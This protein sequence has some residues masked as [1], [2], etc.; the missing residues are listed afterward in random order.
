MS[1]PLSALPDFEENVPQWVTELDS[2]FAVDFVSGPPFE[3]GEALSR[4]VFARL[5]ALRSE[6]P[7]CR[8]LFEIALLAEKAYLFDQLRTNPAAMDIINQHRAK[9]V[10]EALT[11]ATLSQ[12]H[13]TETRGSSLFRAAFVASM[14]FVSSDRTI[15]IGAKVF[16]SM[17]T[18]SPYRVYCRFWR[19]A[20][21]LSVWCLDEWHCDCP[22]GKLFCS[23]AKASLMCL[24]TVLKGKAFTVS[25]KVVEVLSQSKGL[26]AVRLLRLGAALSSREHVS[27]PIV[28]HPD[29]LDFPAFKG[30]CL[31]RR[32]K[33][34]KCPAGGDNYKCNGL[35]PVVMTRHLITHHPGYVRVHYG[36]PVRLDEKNRGVYKSVPLEKQQEITRDLEQ[37]GSASA[38]DEGAVVTGEDVGGVAAESDNTAEDDTHDLWVQCEGKCG[39]WFIVPA[40]KEDEFKEAAYERW[41]CSMATWRVETNCELLP[42][43]GRK[44]KVA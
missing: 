29:V 35:R 13:P 41:A 17:R 7:G 15:S 28:V 37:V 24:E 25:K 12:Y 14:Q 31:A 27:V 3:G 33:S 40:D 42:L 5:D 8:A 39:N 22:Q 6:W 20:G 9:S 2:L 1:P 18:A 16:P 23:H 36:I 21:D 30:A 11:E 19:E 26:P 34:L 32:E 4:D 44:R 43:K 10:S 38:V